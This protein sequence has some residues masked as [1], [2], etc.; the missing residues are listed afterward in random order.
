VFDAGADHLFDRA[1]TESARREVRV[2]LSLS[3]ARG[4]RCPA[5]HRA[6]ERLLRLLDVRVRRALAEDYLDDLA[7]DALLRELHPDAAITARTEAFP[8]LEPV[9]R[10]RVVVDVALR[11]QLVDR[12]GDGVIVELLGA[13]VT[14]DL[15]DAARSSSEVTDCR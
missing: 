1:V 12:R 2:D 6:R 8:L 4:E 7:R 13:Q 15:R 10:E 3:L 5:R 9:A 11:A 14:M